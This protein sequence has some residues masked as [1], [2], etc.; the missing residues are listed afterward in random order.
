ME[1][2]LRV[3]RGTIWHFEGKELLYTFSV[4]S[5][6]VKTRNR[7]TNEKVCVYCTVGTEYLSTTEDNIS[8]MTSRY[9][10][11]KCRAINFAPPS[12]VIINIP[13]SFTAPQFLIRLLSLL[14]FNQ[15]LHKTWICISAKLWA[16]TRSILI[17]SYRGK[18]HNL[19]QNK[20]E[21]KQE[22]TWYKGTRDLRSCLATII[23]LWI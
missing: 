11:R 19:K 12:N 7:N 5:H 23:F 20:S 13:L 10:L 8:R 14:I 3:Y 1:L 4:L 6:G 18:R 16:I 9:I 15:G 2:H 17:L 21:A 22:H